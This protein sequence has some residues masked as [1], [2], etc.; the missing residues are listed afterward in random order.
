MK[1]RKIVSLEKS[2]YPRTYCFVEGVFGCQKMREKKINLKKY[3][4]GTFITL[5]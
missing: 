2:F 3:V 1:Q 4:S 5:P